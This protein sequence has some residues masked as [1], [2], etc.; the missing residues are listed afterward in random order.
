LEPGF[1]QSEI[2]QVIFWKTFKDGT[3]L[4]LLNYVDDK[5]YF[6]TSKCIIRGFK[7]NLSGRFEVEFKGLA[8]WYLLMQIQQDKDF[9]FTFDQSSYVK[10]IAKQFLVESAGVAENRKTHEA[11]LPFNFIPAVADCSVDEIPVMQLQQKFKIDFASCVGALLYP[12][13]TWPDIIFVLNKLA[14]LS[15]KP[16]QKCIDVMIHLVCYLYNN[17]SLSLQF[18]SNISKDSP[19]VW[20]MVS[21][22]Q[23]MV[24]CPGLFSLTLCSK[25]MLMKVIVLVVFTF[26][27]W[28]ELLP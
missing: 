3:I 17:L 8:Y 12:S 14:K 23:K 2:S 27:V 25:M 13:Y 24:E 5:L 19:A 11:P 21:E 9:N 26:Y 6:A 16:R 1:Q 10:A 7:K 22:E 18:Y 28:V 15:C 4:K 20:K